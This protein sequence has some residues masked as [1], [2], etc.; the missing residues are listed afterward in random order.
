MGQPRPP[1]TRTCLRSCPQARA[2]AGNPPRTGLSGQFPEASCPR[3]AS[4][5]T[6]TGFGSPCAPPSRQLIADG[7]VI[8]IRGS[9]TFA[10]Q[11]VGGPSSA[12]SPTS[13]PAGR[14]PADEGPRDR[15]NHRPR[16]SRKRS[17][18]RTAS[19]RTRC[20]GCA[21]RTASRWPSKAAG[22]P[23]RRAGSARPRPHRFAL[24]SA[25]PGVRSAGGRRHP[26]VAA[27]RARATTSQLLDVEPGS[28]CW[29]CTGSP[30]PRSARRGHH[31]LVPERQVPGDDPAGPAQP[32]R[33]RATEQEVHAQAPEPPHRTGTTEGW[34]CCNARPSLMLPIAVLPAA[35][36]CSGWARTTCSARSR[37]G[38][39]GRDHQLRRRRHLRPTCRCCSPSVSRS[40]SRR[41]PT[42]PPRSPPPSA[43]WCSPG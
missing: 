15:G 2:V 39:P 9:G 43:T 34:L 13:R 32:V 31:F 38:H 33:S 8:R 36:I 17:D 10:T 41:R 4:W 6:A 18:W 40:V 35:A 19:R 37:A 25:R 22:T 28:P 5:P 29:W 42:A 14:A 11:A 23:G 26:T 20:A 27:E 1:D 12:R 7:H 3:S 24:R 21:S 30:G 16:R